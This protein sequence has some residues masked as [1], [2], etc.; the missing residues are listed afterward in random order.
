MK[1]IKLLFIFFPA[2]AF[3]TH[4]NF[5][6]PGLNFSSFIGIEEK[7]IFFGGGFHISIADILTLNKNKE[8]KVMMIIFPCWL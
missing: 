8:K 2:L 5:F 1:I 4:V 6:S 7:N 3:S